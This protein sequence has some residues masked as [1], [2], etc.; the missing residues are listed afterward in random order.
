ML[1]FR[2]QFYTQSKDFV[3]ISWFP[4]SLP[5]LAG[6][7]AAVADAVT[8]TPRDTT[9]GRES[10]RKMRGSQSSSNIMRD[11]DDDAAKGDSSDGVRSN[12]DP[13]YETSLLEFVTM[14]PGTDEDA[15]CAGLSLPESLAEVCPRSPLQP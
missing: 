4:P 8:G 15:E 7:G 10:D 11:D 1:C 5:V 13:R 9:K 6:V 12:G 14:S 3:S 2:D